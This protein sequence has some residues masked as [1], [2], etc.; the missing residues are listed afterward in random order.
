MAGSPN[1]YRIAEPSQRLS[2]IGDGATVALSRGPASVKVIDN[3]I[4]ASFASDSPQPAV[5]HDAALVAAAATVSTYGWRPN[6]LVVVASGTISSASA[7]RPVPGGSAPSE[8][9]VTAPRP[10]AAVDGG[11]ESPGPGY[12]R[13]RG[14]PPGRAREKGRGHHADE[15][16]ALPP[17]RHGDS[18]PMRTTAR[19][20]GVARRRHAR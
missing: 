9:V 13:A 19:R 4:A 10:A 20:P 5:R 2:V 16:A 3:M 1:A 8:G 14:R 7:T 18:R 6:A 11:V 17:A 12:L 15:V